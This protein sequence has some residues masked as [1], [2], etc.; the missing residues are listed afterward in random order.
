MLDGYEKGWSGQHCEIW[1]SEK[2]VSQL[3]DLKF[4]AK[5]LARAKFIAEELAENGGENLNDLKFK[6]EGKFPTGRPNGAKTTIWVI[7]AHQLRMYGGFVNLNGK[8]FLCVEVAKKQQNK[9]DQKQLKRIG[10]K[11]G[12]LNG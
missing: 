5:D 6:S 11:L 4:S 8:K 3:K 9:A 10:K 12:D 7:K 2:A 1:L